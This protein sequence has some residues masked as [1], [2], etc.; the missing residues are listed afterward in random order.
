MKKLTKII[1]AAA[2]FTMMLVTTVFAYSERYRAIPSV[3]ITVQ[4]GELSIGD[5]LLG[6]QPE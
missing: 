1:L 2:V 4:T 3:R 5:E 6:A